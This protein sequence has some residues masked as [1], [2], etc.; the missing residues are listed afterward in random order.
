MSRWYEIEAAQIMKKPR[1]MI[2]MVQ[3]LCIDLSAPKVVEEMKD[4]CNSKRPG[5][6]HFKAVYMKVLQMFEARH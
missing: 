3:R 5:T 1:S 2:L 4:V 6:E